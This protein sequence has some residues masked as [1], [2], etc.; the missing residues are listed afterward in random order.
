MP[1]LLPRFTDQQAEDEQRIAAIIL[2]AGELP[3]NENGMPLRASA[4]GHRSDR[5]RGLPIISRGVSGTAP[6]TDPLQALL[7]KE[8]ARRPR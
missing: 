3:E 4:D 1:P 8:R 7:A 5:R 6:G 2:E